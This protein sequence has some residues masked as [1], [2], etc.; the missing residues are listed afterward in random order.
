[1]NRASLS[2][3]HTQKGQSTAWNYPEGRE[4]KSAGCIARATL[5][6]FLVWKRYPDGDNV[7]GTDE[8]ALVRGLSH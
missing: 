6:L 8:H 2:L 4:I 5:L 7:C 1:M 3:L